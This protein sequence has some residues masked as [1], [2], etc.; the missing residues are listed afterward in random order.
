MSKLLRKASMILGII[1]KEDTH[2]S[3]D[4]QS[5]SISN[6]SDGGSLNIP[7]SNDN[8]NSILFHDAP[9]EVIPKNILAFRTITTLLAMIQQHQPFK[10]SDESQ[11][12]L[13]PAI[14]E[15]SIS[16]A[17][18]TV[19]VTDTDV[20]STVTRSS[21]GKLEVIACTNISHDNG[22]LIE[23]SPFPI[24]SR[25]FLLTRNFRRSNPPSGNEN[26]DPIIT[27][28]TIPPTLEPGDDGLKQY[29][30]KRW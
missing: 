27:E 7:T 12:P 6:P 1:P 29:L 20:V 16:T 10:L 4:Q 3:H 15:L 5:Q 28:T 8:S 23:Q 9:P 13:D 19:A 2:H 21:P 22:Q 26:R 18:S 14:H 25:I 17:F 24:M 30:E 11:D